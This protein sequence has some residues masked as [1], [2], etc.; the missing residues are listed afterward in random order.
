MVD[1]S[2]VGEVKFREGYMTKFTQVKHFLLSLRRPSCFI[3]NTTA[4]YHFS[5]FKVKANT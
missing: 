2:P 3:E 1:F 4:S 5:A